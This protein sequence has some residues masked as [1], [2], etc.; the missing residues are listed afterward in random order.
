MC[1]AQNAAETEPVCDDVPKGQRRFSVGNAMNQ[2]PRTGRINITLTTAAH[3][4]ALAAESDL[5]VV[6]VSKREVLSGAVGD[7]VDRLMHLSDSANLTRKF[8]DNLILVVDGYGEDPRELHQIPDVVAFVRAVTRQWPYWFHFL[9]KDGPSIGMILQL[10][11]DQQ[12][13][14]NEG[15]LLG[16][17]FKSRAQLSEQM[18]LLFNALNRLCECHRFSPEEAIETTNKVMESIDRVTR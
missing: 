12:E 5:I 13:V 1:T 7:T 3:I 15:T 8:R 18:M 10:L 14:R 2:Q 4:D 6:E 11:C 9:E 17:G 16:Y